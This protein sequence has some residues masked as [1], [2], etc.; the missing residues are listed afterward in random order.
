VAGPGIVNQP[1][2]NTWHFTLTGGREV[3]LS[4]SEEFNV[5][6]TLTASGVKVELYYLPDAASDTLEAPRHAL[7]VAADALALY[8]ELYGTYP[9]ARMVVV[10]GDFPDGMEFSGLVFVSE[11]WFRTWTGI[12]ADWLTLITAHEVAHQWWYAMVGNDQG[13]YPYIDEALAIYSEVLF[14]ERYHPEAVEWWW[15][16]RVMAYAPAGYVDSTVYDFSSA[17]GYI[18]AVYLRGAL[19]MKSLREDLGDEA[20][21]AWMQQ[22]VQ[23]MQGGVATPVDFWGALSIKR[24]PKRANST[25]GMRTYCPTLRICPDGDAL[26]RFS[27]LR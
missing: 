20:F 11:A 8:E 7:H 17:R 6:S 4:I 27:N 25:C 15:N 14:L 21:F 1:N 24:R 26:S 5:L 10:E 2:P 18:N 19:M 16:F 3:T 13:Y 22:Y 12:A 23:H 9:H